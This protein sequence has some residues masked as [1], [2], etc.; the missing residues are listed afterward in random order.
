[1]ILL[2]SN[3]VASYKYKLVASASGVGNDSLYVDDLSHIAPTVSLQTTNLPLVDY[4]P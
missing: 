1:M 4:V 2:P 3:L